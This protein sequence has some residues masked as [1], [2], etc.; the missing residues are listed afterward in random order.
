M[1]RYK[2]IAI[3]ALAC[4]FGACTSWLDVKPEDEIAEE[5]LFSKG[6]GYR[7]A[8]NGVYK[9]LANKDM[10][11][12]QMTWGVMDAMAQY[13]IRSKT[14]QNDLMYAALYDFKSDYVKSI[15]EQFW[16]TAYNAVA[17]CN[18]ILKNIE[19][20]DADLFEYKAIERQ[21]IKGEALA[22]RA[23]IQFDMLR[24][25]APAPSQAGNQK[26]IPYVSDYPSLVSQKRTVNEC[27][28]LMIQ[29]LKDAREL[30]FEFDST[31]EDRFRTSVRFKGALGSDRFLNSRGYRLNYYAINGIL[32][33]VCLYAGKYDE[34]YAAAKK[35][36]DFNTRTRHFAFT[37]YS[38]I[39]KGNVKCTDDVIAGLFSSKQEEWD[40][41]VN[42]VVNASG[43][44]TFLA[45]TNVT[46]IFG[47]ETR[48]DY[49]R[50][51]LIETFNYYERSVKNRSTWNNTID[52]R[53]SLHTVP[54]IRMSE[55]YYI[56]GEAIYE[57]QPD[58]AIQYLTDVKKG[59][60]VSRPDLTAI[61]SL[62]T[63][64]DAI[65]NDAWREFIG[66]GQMFY[67]YKRLNRPIMGY[68]ETIQPESKIF[69]LPIPESETDIH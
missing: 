41:E 58:E 42:D 30:V 29:D 40:S 64:R 63:Y 39:S 48:S 65:Q 45:L 67:F 1:K 9:T 47:E 51:K 54:L 57:T 68:Y 25:Y 62:E 22:L 52:G 55:V 24:L 21:L 35:V 37:S 60:G 5:E 46:D 23:F 66:E 50:T 20:T 34:A 44:K 32:A 53:A 15:V 4:T 6:E 61:A 14:G 69:V 36:I 49:R 2:L 43:E 33:R 27:L 7:N 18:N 13:Y 19:S 31:Y 17:N 56:A 26:Y 12:K 28:D 59:R 8:L 3:I 10:Y 11:G 16:K 38:S